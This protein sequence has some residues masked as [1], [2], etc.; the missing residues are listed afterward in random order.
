M[1]VHSL[2]PRALVCAAFLLA[3][4]ALLPAGAVDAQLGLP[5]LDFALQPLG[6][7][8]TGAFDESA[9]EIVAYDAAT[10][11]LFVVNGD[12]DAV[13]VLDVSNPTAPVKAFAIDVSPWGDSPNSV[14]VMDGLVAVAVEIENSQGQ[15]PGKAVFF[16]TSGAYIDD[17][18]VG[19]LPD[20]ITFSPDG[21]YVL[22]ANEGE[23]NDDYTYDPEGSVSVITL[24][25]QSSRRGASYRFSS[26][27]ADFRAFDNVP[28]DPGIRIFGP[29]ASVSQDLEPEYIGVDR[30]SRRAYV[31]LQEN[32][33]LAVVDIPFCRVTELV[34]LGTKDHSLLQNALDASDRDDAINIASWPV[35][36][37]YMPD[38]LA[39][40]TASSGQYL[41]TANE[42]DAR[43]YDG[44]AEEERVDDLTLD[45]IA[46]PNAAFLQQEENLGR[47]TVTTVNGDTD[48]DGDYDELYAYG[49]RS[50][51]IWDT[52][53]Q[54]V[55]DGG[56]ELEQL[57]AQELPDEFNSTNDENGSFDS[58]SDAKGPEPEGVTIG[59]HAGRTL[60][61]LGLER[62]GGV[63]I[64]DITIPTQSR[65][66]GYVNTRD[67]S[68][69]AEAGTAGDLAPEG[70]AF[71]PGADSP[72]GTPLLAVAYEVS[73][74]TTL[75]E[76]DLAP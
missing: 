50:L 41:V 52:S 20:M 32:N 76:L 6:T 9:A 53:G 67:F 54:L 64:Y 38:A 60:A 66:A 26:C 29:G 7:Y 73:G 35:M 5:P 69:D 58:R 22:V 18:T 74:T 1:N 15:Q 14:A 19:A 40:Y 31:A 36:G 63:V 37:M 62:I 23:P 48:G 65:I 8:E 43:D 25:R 17:V 27:T 44:F 30:L 39:V 24:R 70:L 75:Y 57:I 59:S 10:Q 56:D 51:S 21:R 4:C 61:F 47:L 71:I 3:L 33:A 2:R 49:A 11:R 12:D 55:W 68:G 46:F 13:D 16:D 45:P 72:T 42:G 34:A 28:L